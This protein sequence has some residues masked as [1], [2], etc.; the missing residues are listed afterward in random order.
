MSEAKPKKRGVHWLVQVWVFFHLFMIF[1]W[2]LPE[3][4][5][6]LRADREPKVGGDPPTPKPRIAAR[7]IPN[8]ILLYNRDYIKNSPANYYLYSTGFWQYWNMFSPNPANVDVYLDA[9]VTY[10]D[11]TQVVFEYPVMQKLSVFE[12]YFKERYRKFVENAHPDR[13]S[14]KW[15]AVAQAIA[16]Q[17]YQGEGNYPMIV[18]LRRHFKTVMPPG[19][20]TDPKYEEYAF[21][22]YM[23]D[24]EK[25]KRQVHG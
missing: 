4:P 7:D 16:Y 24:I 1:S 5:E 9:L 14:Y 15:P 19:Q 11:G 22:S 8:Y 10:Q 20:F 12:R 2:S 25:L 21:F 3:A 23:V 18:T 17:S 13:Y 6:R